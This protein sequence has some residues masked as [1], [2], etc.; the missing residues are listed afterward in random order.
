M[1]IRI[2]LHVYS[3]EFTQHL[4]TGKSLPPHP[5]G[6]YAKKHPACT[7]PSQRSVCSDWSDAEEYVIAYQDDISEPTSSPRRNA[8]FL[9]NQPLALRPVSG[10]S[11]INTV[12][13]KHTPLGDEI[14][15]ETPEDVPSG[16]TS[17]CGE[18]ASDDSSWTGVD[19]ADWHDSRQQAA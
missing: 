11:R 18:P 13:R 7:S 15:G 2:S 5:V 19:E 12:D 14:R 8:P 4:R 3:C 16:N 6:K 10:T 17:D 9:A 1:S